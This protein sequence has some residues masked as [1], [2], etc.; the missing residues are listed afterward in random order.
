MFWGGAVG[1]CSIVSPLLPDPIFRK[2]PKNCHFGQIFGSLQNI[3]P[4]NNAA[5]VNSATPKNCSLKLN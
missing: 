4:G 5:T 3:G 1:S 2:Q